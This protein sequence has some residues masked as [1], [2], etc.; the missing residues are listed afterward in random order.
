MQHPQPLWVDIAHYRTESRSRNA[1]V[2]AILTLSP[3]AGMAHSLRGHQ[4]R[5]HEFPRPAFRGR[6][7][8]KG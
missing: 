5:D 4:L 7:L 2:S 1:G 8:G 6:H 3:P